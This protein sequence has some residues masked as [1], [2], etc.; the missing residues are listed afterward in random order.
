MNILMTGGTGFVGTA[1]SRRLAAAG[2]TLV[3]YLR[4]RTRAAVRLGRDNRFVTD[5]DQIA[6]DESIDAIVN[7]AGAPIAGSLWSTAYRRQ[8]V[9]SRVGTTKALVKLAT[10]L[11]RPPKVMV[12]ASAAGYYGDGGDR[13]LTEEAPT[14]DIFM[15]TLCQRWEHAAEEI[16]T[17]GVR[18]A[19][20][21]I[22]VV[23]GTDGGAFPSLVRPIRFGL[24]AVIASGNQY[25][26]WIHKT[27]LLRMIEYM[28]DNEDIDG[29]YN[30][31]A[32]DARTQ[33]DF[34]RAIADHLRR[35]MF[36]RVPAVALKAPL[37]ELSDL[38][39]KGQRMSADRI[40]GAGFRFDFPD[41]PAALDDLFG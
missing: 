37:G 6:T 20:P 12:S 38:F 7:L 8:L 15:S 28:L 25:F 9:D 40:L 30:A 17:L 22:S 27:D 39:L 2:H 16:R 3:F 32:P 10:R 24:A 35:P 21:R 18:L 23:L 19:I 36:L 26:P 41:L 31:A 34:N 29:S 5:L 13:W 14:Q 1:L 11:E 33:R 4:K